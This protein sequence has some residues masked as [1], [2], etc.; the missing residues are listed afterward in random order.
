MGD[1]RDIDSDVT[2]LPKAVGTPRQNT[3]QVN[4]SRAALNKGK[5]LYTIK[6]MPDLIRDEAIEFF[7]ANIENLLGD[8]ITII[9]QTYLPSNMPSSDPYIITVFKLLDGTIDAG[10]I[11]RSRLAYVQ[12]IRV[13]QALERII[14]VERR[15]RCIRRECGKGNATV[16]MQ[17]YKS[18]Q[19]PYVSRH[20]P[21][22]RKQIARWWTTFAGPSPLFVTTHSEAV[23]SLSTFQ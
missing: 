1:P 15:A 7:D 2:D 5:Q 3:R 20:G 16:A 17:I 4:S 10:E 13:F 14:D 8:C 12:L 11:I 6:N 19:P 23:E 22:K 9:K 21:Q 18:A